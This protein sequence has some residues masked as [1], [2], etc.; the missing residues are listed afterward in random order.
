MMNSICKPYIED[1]V[2]MDSANGSITM[3][4]KRGNRDTPAL[5]FY[6]QG[7]YLI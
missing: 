1:V 7:I 5:F 6:I 3:A 4:N 2:L